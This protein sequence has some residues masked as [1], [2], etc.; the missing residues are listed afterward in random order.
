MPSLF[1]FFCFPSRRSC[2]FPS[3]PLLRLLRARRLSCQRDALHLRHRRFRCQSHFRCRCRYRCRCQVGRRGGKQGQRVDRSIENERMN[4]S[5]ISFAFLSLSLSLS[6]FP[7]SRLL[8]Q[9]PPTPILLR[10]HRR[11]R[12]A[13]PLLRS[14]FRT[15]WPPAGAWSIR[16]RRWSTSMSRTWF[17]RVRSKGKGW[18]CARPENAMR[19]EKEDAIGLDR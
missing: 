6:L 5:S 12:R 19:L 17:F 13:L 14:C 11:R 9:R 2:P 7:F 1:P 18:V 3:S 8:V 16:R 4:A 15:R 10:L